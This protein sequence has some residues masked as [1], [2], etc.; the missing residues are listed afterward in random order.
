M[1][2]KI[3]QILKPEEASHIAQFTQE[4]KDWINSHIHDRADGEPGVECVVRGKNDDGDYF[5]LTPEE[6]VR[7]YYAYK[8]ME[9]YGYS[10]EQIGFELP[11][12]YAGKE[13]IKDKRI[14]IAVFNKD[15]KSKIDMIIEVKRPEIKDENNAADGESSTP[16]QQMQSYCRLKQ[17]QIGVIANGD[18]LLKFYEAPAF[19]EAL[20]IDKFPSNGEDIEEWKNNRRFTLKQLIQEDRLQTETLKDIIL[21]V[22]QRFSANDSSDKAFEEIFKL[23][24]IKLYD[25][26]LSSQ[27]A[28]EIAI[29][30]KHGTAFKDI[31]DSGFRVM[32]FRIKESDSLDDIFRNM[33]DLFDEAKNK[34]PGVFVA[35]DVLDM[36]AATV[37]SCV[38]ELQNVKLFNSNL[39]VVDDAFEHLVNQNQKEGMGQYFTPRYVIDMCVK[40]LN[41]KPNEKMIDTAAGSCGFPM[42]AIFHVWKQLNPE[43]FNLFTTR[44]RKPEELAYVKN[45]VFGIDFS[46]KSVRVGRMLNII[47]GDGHTNVIYLNSLDYPNW[48]KNFLN[49]DKWQGK[50]HD[51]FAKLANL[52]AAPS[53]HSDKKKYEAF[54]F[55]ILMANPPFA[56]N[57]DNSEQLEIYDLGYNAKGKL[58]NKIG[59]D[60]LFIERNL[61]FLKPGGRMA[62]VLPQGRFNNSGDKLI[63]DYI[64]E[65]CRILAVVGLHGNVFKPHTGTKT[66]VLFVQKWTDENCGF[67][68]ICPKPTPD[69]NGNIDYPIFFATMQEPSKDNS[70]DKIYVTEDYITWNSYRYITETHYVRKAD[71]QEVTEE[72]YNNAAKKS[73][74]SVKVSTRKEVEEHHTANGSADFVKDLFIT[75]YGDLDSHRKWILKN[76]YFVLKNKKK[77]S[78]TYDESL[79]IEEYLKLPEGDQ[80][81]YKE[82]NILGANPHSLISL[83]EYKALDT[84]VQKYYLVAEEVSERTER[85]KDTHGH[86]F[87]KHD[88]FNHDPALVNSNPNN[89]YSQDG[90]AEAFIEFAKK[91]GLSFFQ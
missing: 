80:A 10:K 86:I 30:M 68:N 57:L 52:S 82:V 62:V 60:I 14:D 33:S 13:V 45:N 76:V 40:M 90:I 26:V 28:D 91:E 37:K 75:E 44:A 7:Q 51:G 2:K 84:T 64:A 66:S 74:Y 21:N 32:K 1:P 56:G 47:A 69:E 27:D 38:K 78:S 19:D 59:R 3:D 72:E 61:K 16:F 43:A 11:A 36:Q 71:K 22:E 8:L 9:I 58:Q 18:N 65:R 89:I 17:P 29:L 50:Y 25:E 79:T 24:F 41:P 15:D 23:I 88:L 48:K 63:R 42:H 83:D 20:V 4:D 54:N 35:E 67:P 53:A 77:D 55:D 34:W 87:V 12:V 39:E 73:D 49:V 6:I 31:D 85:V 70:G 81:H 46:E 5:K